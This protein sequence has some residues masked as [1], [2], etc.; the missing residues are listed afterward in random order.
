M[1]SQLRK[2]LIFVKII[3]LLELDENAEVL[4]KKEV[5]STVKDKMSTGT[6]SQKDIDFSGQWLVVDE[7]LKITNK[8]IVYVVDEEKEKTWIK[9]PEKY[10]EENYLMDYDSDDECPSGIDVL[11]KEDGYPIGVITG[12]KSIKQAKVDN[13]LDGHRYKGELGLKINEQYFLS[14]NKDAGEFKLVKT[15]KDWDRGKHTI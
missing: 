11:V 5:E 13:N 3:E 9:L 12:C 1:L 8:E 14:Y 6:Y 4:N 7:I 2:G 15:N 10:V